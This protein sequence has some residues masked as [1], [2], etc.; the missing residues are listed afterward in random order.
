MKVA[1]VVTIPVKI[2]NRRFASNTNIIQDILDA[3]EGHTI[4]ITFKK[5][6]NK[7][8][9]KQNNYYWGVIVPIVQGAIKDSWGEI[10]GINKTHE[11]LKENF[12]FKERVNQDTGEV[13]RIPR[14]TT[15]NST[16]EQIEYQDKIRGFCMDFFYIDIPPPEKEIELQF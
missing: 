8:S 4:D 12:N 2:L 7:R 16:L 1:K 10:W 9:L 13:T 15:E 11:Y 6:F 5:R 14:S 3:Y